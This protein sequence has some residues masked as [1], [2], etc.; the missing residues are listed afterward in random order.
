LIFPPAFYVHAC[1]FDRNKADQTAESVQQQ[2]IDI[3]TAE[4]EHKLKKLVRQ[5]RQK[6]AIATV[7]KLRILLEHNGTSNP[8]GTNAMIF[9]ITFC[10]RTV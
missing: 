7:L 6:A 2:I 9:P 8:N 5:L 1:Q 10:S 4:S 3:K